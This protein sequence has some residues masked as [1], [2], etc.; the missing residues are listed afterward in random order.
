MTT[1][2]PNTS[3]QV[4]AHIAEFIRQDTAW[5]AVPVY[6]GQTSEDYALPMVAVVA[7]NSED[8]GHDADCSWRKITL[9]ISVLTSL[10]IPI[11]DADGNTE[12]LDPDAATNHADVA[13]L[14]AAIL[15][16]YAVPTQISG[17]YAN[18]F[19]WEPAGIQEQQSDRHFQT[20]F[21]FTASAAPY[22]D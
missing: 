14:L 16:G 20:S 2:Q 13:G 12:A 17:A 1:L 19:G 15:Q 3:A 11:A 5:G 21:T 7:T 10:F 18:V 22:F 4:E 9:Q 8:I 6:E